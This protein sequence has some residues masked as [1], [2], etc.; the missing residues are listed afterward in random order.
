V[1]E[2]YNGL[3]TEEKN[4]I[5]KSIVERVEYTRLQEYIDLHITLL[6]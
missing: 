1:L 2:K 4:L 3:D 6:L 5:L